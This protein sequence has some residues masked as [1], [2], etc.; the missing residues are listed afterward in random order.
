MPGV[1]RRATGSSLFRVPWGCGIFHIKSGSSGEHRLSMQT[2]FPNDR[3]LSLTGTENFREVGGYPTQD[4]RRLRRGLIWR[5]ARLD[6]LTQEDAGNLHTLGIRLVADL[7]RASER[8]ESSSDRIWPG[9]D[10]RVVWWDDLS[11]AAPSALADLQHSHG[12][13]EVNRAV[14]H[15]YYELMAE[16]HVHRLCDLYSAIAG[17]DLPVLIHCAAGK[18]RTGFAVALLLKLLGIRHE[19]ILADYAASE[20][21]IDWDRPSTAAAMEAMHPKARALINRSDALYLKAALDRIDLEYG[22]ALAFAKTRLNLSDPAIENL[23][24]RLLES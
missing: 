20:R 18:D 1:P 19:Y 17:G 5:S 8:A 2:L 14:I 21:L 12:D 11:A 6:A 13:A 3:V 9:E 23:H 24:A 16:A 10:V 7:R 22:S 4:G 15:R